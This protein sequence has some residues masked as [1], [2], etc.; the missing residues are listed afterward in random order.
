MILVV[1]PRVELAA[2]LCRFFE[3]TGFT[4][5]HAND[6]NAALPMLE[7]GQVDLLV[8]GACGRYGPGYQLL[9]VVRERWSQSEVPV[10]CLIAADD[11]DCAVELLREGASDTATEPL[12]VEALRQRIKALL[13]RRQNEAARI[14]DSR[15]GDFRL[16]RTIGVGGMGTVWAAESVAEKKPYAIKILSEAMSQDAEFVERFHREAALASRVQHDNVVRLYGSG[17]HR[18]RHFIVMELLAGRDLS[19]CCAGAPL[20]VLEALHLTRQICLA[21]TELHQR[22]VVHR[23]IKP[24]NIMLTQGG[25]AKL[26]DFGVAKDLDA[27]TRLTKT[28]MAVGSLVYASPEQMEGETDPRSDI[29]SLG[30]TLYFMLVGA[31]PFCGDTLQQIIEKK[32]SRA[33][34]ASRVRPSIPAAVDDFVARLMAT[35]PSRRPSTT[36]E[37]LAELDRLLSDQRW[38]T[39]YT[40]HR[41]LL[42]GA[43]TL[44]GLSAFT[45]TFFYLQSIG[46][47]G[48]P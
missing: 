20:N 44:V 3:S 9:R 48:A 31:P 32:L 39:G 33:P 24:E 6:R 36:Q 35:K 5:Q 27:A 22:G 8:L 14:G 13:Q 12:E 45:A 2:G 29:Y 34:R 19:V 1:D 40:W 30:C 7:R 21:L 25:V 17:Q 46:Y 16:L 37:V 42:L 4:A 11:K 28:G 18:G 10:V 23:D 43:A 38:Y 41:A 26:T 15:I 47:F